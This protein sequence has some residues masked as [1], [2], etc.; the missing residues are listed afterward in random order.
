MEY[1]LDEWAMFG[2]FVGDEDEDESVFGG[3]FLLAGLI[4]IV[5]IAR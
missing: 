3:V 2:V 4:I 1:T 5:I